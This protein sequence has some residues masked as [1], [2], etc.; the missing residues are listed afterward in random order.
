MEEALAPV[1]AEALPSDD[2]EA[3]PLTDEAILRARLR[4]LVRDRPWLA[5]AAAA[6]AGSM[7]GGVWFSR[8]GRLAFAAATGFVAH[9]LWH[10]EGELGVND[11]V[12]SM[13]RHRTQ[14]M[15]RHRTQKMRRHRTQKRR[16]RTQKMRKRRP[17]WLARARRARASS[18]R[19]NRR[20]VR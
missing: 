1:D 17:E 12:A 20:A 11:V 3:S 6:A 15:R 5:V 16:H 19:D 9:E 10:R 18:R 4:G 2:A 13:R 7:L 14:K 8:A